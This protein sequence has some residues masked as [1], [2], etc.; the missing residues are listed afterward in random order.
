[1]CPLP[2][3]ESRVRTSLLP[4]VSRL[5][6]KARRRP[7]PRT[8]RLC[9]EQLEPRVVLTA[10][11]I[12]ADFTGLTSGGA[13]FVG[14]STNPA[15]NADGRFVAYQS[16]AEAPVTIDDNDS[17]D[18]FLQATVRD[19]RGNA[20]G[21]LDHAAEHDLEARGAGDVNHLHRLADPA[22]LAEL[23]VDAVEEADAVKDILDG[24]AALVGK[25]RPQPGFSAA[26][27]QFG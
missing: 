22:A 17:Q 11:L 18:V 5:R 4:V 8:R 1:M 9:G 3:R 6:G 2:L 10:E 15:V 25:Q 20:E 26:R 27:P 12:S 21:R 19:R 16:F 13:A 7:R 23:D 14:A 24:D